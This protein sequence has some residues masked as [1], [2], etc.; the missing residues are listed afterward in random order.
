MSVGI[1]LP[2]LTVAALA[3]GLNP[4]GIGML[5]MFLGYL[6]VFGAGGKA[7]QKKL[8]LMGLIYILSVFVTYLLLG[9]VFYNLA[10]YFQRTQL[11]SLLFQVMG[12]V[13]VLAGAIQVKD[14]FWPES[15]IHLR[16][17]EWASKKLL[18]LME[19]ISYPM[20]AFLGMAMT[21]AGTPCMLPLYV[22]TATVLVN[23]G[24]RTAEVLG[25]F[26]YYNIIF[27]APLL[28][29]LFV[30]AKGSQLTNIKELEHKWGRWSRLLMGLLM[31]GMGIWLLGQ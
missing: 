11:A 7:N 8:W 24:L 15:P 4:C 21:A 22:G 30:L 5:V 3:N 23:S 16:A 9:L 12:A 29:V 6:V 25:Y 20:A 18:G 26:I 13:L 14:G 10:Y 2:L 1:N 28:V 19:K 27:I 17:P 31:S